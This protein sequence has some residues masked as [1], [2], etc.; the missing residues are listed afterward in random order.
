MQIWACLNAVCQQQQHVMLVLTLHPKPLA[1][2]SGCVHGRYTAFS[3]RA[4]TS[5]QL[6][7]LVPGKPRAEAESVA[8]VK[9]GLQ[10]SG[11]HC[12]DIH[13]A[14]TLQSCQSHQATAH[15]GCLTS[16]TSLNCMAWWPPLLQLYLLL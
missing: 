2:A 11:Q 15:F 3:E 6:Q 8:A 10:S 14:V 9:T 16:L 5:L 13:I 12:L 7:A 1:D 4:V